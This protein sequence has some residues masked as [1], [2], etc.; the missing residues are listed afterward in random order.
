[1]KHEANTPA[2][3]IPGP[4]TMDAMLNMV[5]HIICTEGHVV[6][7]VRGEEGQMPFGYT[8]GLHET[9][10]PEIII[11]GADPTSSQA[12]LNAV[13][14]NLRKS[15]KRPADGMEI[16]GITEFPLRLQ[17]VRGKA[18]LWIAVAKKR[19][20]RINAASEI[21]VLQ[22]LWAD[23]NGKFPGEEGCILPEA[24]QFQI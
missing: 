24:Y 8:V 19:A 16:S 4:D 1:M 10:W 20:A 14:T 9:G 15:E 21:E 2:R 7:I 6:Q 23:R 5:D 22:L 11:V 18:D 17:A 13:V 12:V 3:I